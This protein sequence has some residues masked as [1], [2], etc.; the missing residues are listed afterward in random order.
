MSVDARD[1]PH[2]PPAIVSAVFRVPLVLAG[3][4]VLTTLVFVF[5]TG[6]S[7]VTNPLEIGGP[8]YP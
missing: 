1:Y 4:V 5:A 3:L 7:F 2:L 6:T 8:P